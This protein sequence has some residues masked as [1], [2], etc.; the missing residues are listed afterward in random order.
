MN[1]FS[2]RRSRPDWRGL[3]ENLGENLRSWLPTG[4]SFLILLGI[5]VAA[6]L[7]RA[8]TQYIQ[9]DEFAVKQVDVPLPL[10]TGAKGI[11][12]NIYQTGVHWLTPGCEK[13]IVFPKSLRV[14]TL[15]S[16][17]KNET[18]REKFVRFEEAAHIQT[19]DGFFI[20]LDISVLYRVVNPYQ[21][22]VEFGAG[23]LYEQNGI[24]LQAEPT[25]K[26]TLGTLHPEDFFNAVRRVAKQNECRDRFNDFLLSRGLR[27]EHVLIRYPK[28]HEA[29]QARIEARNIQEQTKQKNVEESKLAQSMASLKEV[30]MQGQAALAIKLMEGSNFVT[31][32]TAQMEAY[33][34][35]RKSEGDRVIALAEAEKQRMINMGYEGSGSERLIGLQWARV[36]SG[37]DTIILPSGGE[38]GFNPLDLDKLM[39]QLK[40][41]SAEGK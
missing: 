9:P 22:V 41:K 38:Q 17:D 11:H 15:H 33:Q 32:Y 6:I 14:I 31:R 21:V 1:A 25:L 37:L 30:E 24:I 3:T 39:Q 16:Q 40:L 19:S 27:V 2:S 4:F 36:L 23:S 20:N 7:Y 26:A 34:R 12:T 18:A 13:F 10:L 28:Y 29:V 35:K 5:V 8:C